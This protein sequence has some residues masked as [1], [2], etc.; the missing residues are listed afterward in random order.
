MTVAP[1]TGYK[2]VIDSVELHIT[3][4]A[5]MNDSCRFQAYGLV[6]CF[7]PQLMQPPYSIPEGTKIPIGDPLVYK[8][9]VDLINDS[10]KSYPSY[11]ALGASNWRGSPKSIHKFVW[12]Y[13]EGVT[14]LYAKYGME[15]RLSLDHN[16]PCGGTNVTVT[17]HC[18][19]GLE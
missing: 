6:E 9:I 14:E 4:D 16:E 1:L 11:P 19:R 3:E 2:L 12:D 18:T 8:T 13:N 7:A 10:N 5:V 17:L 15:I